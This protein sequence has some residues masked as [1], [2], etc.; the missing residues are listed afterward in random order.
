MGITQASLG[1]ES[2]ISA[3]SFQETTRILSEAAISGSV[4]HLYGLKENVIVGKLIPA[5]TGIAHLEK[6]IWVMMFL[7]LNVK[8]K[9]KRCVNVK[10]NR[11]NRIMKARSSVVEHCFDV[12]RVSGSIPLAPTSLLMWVGSK[13]HGMQ[14]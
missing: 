14:L 3:A 7:I 2:F 11:N 8:H 4:D 9:K 6:N 12:A 13:Y 10:N 1:T 5:G